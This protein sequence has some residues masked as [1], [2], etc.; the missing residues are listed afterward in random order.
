VLNYGELFLPGDTRDE[1]L[2]STNVC[3]PSLANNELSGPVVATALGEWLRSLK[4]RR[5]SYRIVYVPE[6]IGS[7]AFLSQHIQHL[8]KH[9]IAG[10]NVVCVGD[11]RC[12][13]YLPSRAGNTLSDRVALHVLKHIDTNFKRYS[14]LDNG[15]DERQ[16]CAPGVDLPIATIMRSKYGEYP[17]YHT[18]LDDFSVVTDIGLKGGFLAL[19]SA[20]EALELNLFPLTTTLCEP[21]LGRR[22]LYPTVSTT[23]SAA[24][25]RNMMNAISLS[26]GQHSMLDIADTIGIPIAELFKTIKPLVAAGLLKLEPRIAQTG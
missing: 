1:I 11:E 24:I 21:Q 3:H 9:V 16:Y 8:K 18:S 5:Y 22:G 4:R 17:E 13:S 23:A 7:I 10:F 26:D 25:V 2:L 6:T 20:L 15:S 14:W 12:Y 19:K